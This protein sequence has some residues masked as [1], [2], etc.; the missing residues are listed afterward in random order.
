MIG[1]LGGTGLYEFEKL[2]VLEERKVSTPFGNPSGPVSIG[3]YDGGQ[4]S[5][6]QV[7]FL[8]RHGKRHQ[9]LPSE[10]NY[11]ANIFALKSV[12]VTQ[13]VSTSAVGSLQ[14][15]VRPGDLVLPSQYWD[16]TKGIRNPT[17]FGNGV[18][19]HISTAEPTS[20]SLQNA[21]SIHGQELDFSIHQH[22]TY[23][24]VEGPRLGNRF[25]SLWFQKMGCDVVGMTN[26]PE[27]Y[28]AREAQISYTTLAAVTD[29]DCWLED[30][31]QHVSVDQ[32]LSTYGA[33]LQR[34]KQVLEKL[35]S[36]PPEPDST[37]RNALQN[38]ILSPLNQLS[39]DQRKWIE[40]LRT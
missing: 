7:A 40:V 13:L 32:V 9:L 19:A 33:T 28:L 26:V 18:V 23:V 29:Y 20:A 10:I 14:K 27:V 35:L 4:T 34:L 12:G 30:P 39:E 36:H 1:I 22:K 37:S 11:R 3:V 6:T 5:P 15:E 8:P 38:A 16:A 21:L 31:T 25:E 17:F 24:C 2:K